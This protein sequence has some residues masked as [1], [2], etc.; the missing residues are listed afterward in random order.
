MCFPSSDPLTTDTVTVD[1]EDIS[2]R[3]SALMRHFTVTSKIREKTCSVWETA[4]LGFNR[5]FDMLMSHTYYNLCAANILIMKK[6][7]QLPFTE[8]VF[9]LQFIKNTVDT[10]RHRI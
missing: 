4:R 10:V 5:D 3:M 6:C 9:Y 7:L 2:T 1:P 8:T